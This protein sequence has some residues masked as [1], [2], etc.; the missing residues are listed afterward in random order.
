VCVK[1]VGVMLTKAPVHLLLKEMFALEIDEHKLHKF[2][3]MHHGELLRE[4]IGIA[5]VEFLCKRSACI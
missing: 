5:I 4:C 3:E 1:S 2:L